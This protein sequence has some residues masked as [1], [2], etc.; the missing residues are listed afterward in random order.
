MALPWPRRARN[1]T[2]PLPW[3]G[4]RGA[5]S[6]ENSRSSLAVRPFVARFRRTPCRHALPVW[7]GHGVRPWPHDWSRCGDGSFRCGHRAVARNPARGPIEQV[8]L[9]SRDGGQHGIRSGP[10]GGERLAAARELSGQCVAPRALA[11]SAASLALH[12]RHLI[13]LELIEAALEVVPLDF[14]AG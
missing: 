9:T 13:G 14:G 11:V 10:L 5:A 4:T 3:S 6:W 2:R 7:W 1:S 12:G 8:A